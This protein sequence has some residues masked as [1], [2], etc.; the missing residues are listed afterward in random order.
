MQPELPE[1]QAQEIVR[2]FCAFMDIPWP[3]FAMHAS[4]E[5]VLNTPIILYQGQAYHFPHYP[6]LDW[7]KIIEPE[8]N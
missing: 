4:I 6:K 8:W 3:N 2:R 7:V 5:F 1:L